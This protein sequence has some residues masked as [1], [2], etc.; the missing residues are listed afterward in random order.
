MVLP[1]NNIVKKIIQARAGGAVERC[2][3]IRHLGSYSVAV[4]SWGVA[5]LL[6]YLFPASFDHLVLVCLTHD[7]PEAWVGDIPSPTLRHME[8][9]AEKLV[10]IEAALS[11][12]LD[13]PAESDLSFEEFTILKACDRLEFYLWCREQLLFG[14][15]FVEEGLDEVTKYL[16]KTS[17]PGSAAQTFW[18]NIQEESVKPIQAGV[19]EKVIN[20]DLP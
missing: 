6:H 14:N 5:M 11:R 10:P 13:L 17:L 3:S 1:M 19:I 18:I 16:N 7:V 8:G 12:S 15:E 2:H 4:H 9:M 20:G